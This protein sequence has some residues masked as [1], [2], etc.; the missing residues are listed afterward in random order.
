MYLHTRDAMYLHFIDACAGVQD[1]VACCDRNEMRWPCFKN[2]PTEGSPCS[3]CPQMHYKPDETDCITFES[4]HACDV[5][6]D[7]CKLY[8]WQIWCLANQNVPLSS[9]GTLV[10]SKRML[11]NGEFALVTLSLSYHQLLW[12]QMASHKIW[13]ENHTM[14]F[15]TG[16][17][18][19]FQQKGFQNKFEGFQQKFALRGGM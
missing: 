14:T 17:Y 2:C 11:I 15:T 1:H 19:S 4:C 18:C 7:A 3:W 5:N 9:W 16:Q 12:K 10:A 13:R 8:L 6:K